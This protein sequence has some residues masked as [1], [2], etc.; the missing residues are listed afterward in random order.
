MPIPQEF[1]FSIMF[2]G[3]S[4][5]KELL[6]DS[7]CVIIQTL[8]QSRRLICIYEHRCRCDANCLV[9]PSKTN[10]SFPPWLI[11][12]GDAAAPP[13]G[14][15]AWSCQQIILQRWSN[16]TICE[17]RRSI[18]NDQVPWTSILIDWFLCSI[19]SSPSPGLINLL[20]IT[21]WCM[22][23]AWKYYFMN[24]HEA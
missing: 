7:T 16:S 1:S 24:I 18:R 12:T 17:G 5:L 23:L 9:A 11:P 13:R 3:G 15:T 20:S 2:K 6:S 8:P 10:R 19:N 22:L 21:Q 14:P 4:P